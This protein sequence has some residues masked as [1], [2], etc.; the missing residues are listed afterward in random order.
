MD[1]IERLECVYYPGPIPAN[2]AVLTVLCVLFDKI[3]FPNVY[4]PMGGY[5]KEALRKEIERLEGVLEEDR[6]R[7]S[8]QSYQT[9]QLIGQLKFLEYRLPLDGI[10]EFPTPGDAIF[11]GGNGS[12]RPDGKLARAIYDANYPPRKNFEP[13]FDTSSLKGLPGGEESIIHAGDFFYQ[14]G[15]IQYSAE[16]QIPLIDDGTRDQFGLALPF[17]AQHK[18]N[19]PA[20]A[21]LLAVES[22]GLVLPD[23]PPMTCEELVDF[24]FENEKELRNFR[25]S[26][27]RFATSLNQQLP[28]NP[29]V[30]EL[31]SKVKFIVDTE[32]APALHDLKRDLDNPNRPWQKRI[33]D[34]GRI[35]SAV[36]VGWLSGGPIAPTAAAA[37]T[38]AVLSDLEGRGDRQEAVKRNGLYYLLKARAIGSQ[39]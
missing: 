34:V 37:L 15:A 11:G 36:T 3:H 4:L 22:L 12:K 35:A 5:D 31:N 24:R 14:A 18:D 13:M 27:L 30:E 8:Y 19:A 39:G 29:S 26:M 20:L 7:S 21:T 9:G 16:K 33:A 32:V 25:A 17:K 1:N 38:N 10:L 6:K 2:S 28:D 23:L